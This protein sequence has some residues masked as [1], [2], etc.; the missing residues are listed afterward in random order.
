MQNSVATEFYLS[1]CF[2]DLNKT[3]ALHVFCINQHNHR[4][5]I[6]ANHISIIAVTQSLISVRDENSGT[7]IDKLTVDFKIIYF[8]SKA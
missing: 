3:D 6:L 8:V 1:T 4:Q 2:V 7:G 5:R